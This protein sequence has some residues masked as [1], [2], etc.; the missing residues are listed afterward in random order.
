MQFITTQKRFSASLTAATLAA[1]TISTLSTLSTTLSAQVISS[2]S[3]SAAQLVQ[4]ESLST[5]A[6]SRAIFLEANPGAGL[7]ELE[8]QITRVYGAAFSHGTNA[9]D[10]AEKFLRAHSGMLSS[11]FAQLMAIGPNGDGTHVLPV[12]FNEQDGSH[13]F[14][15]VGYTQHVNGVPVF[16]ADVRCLVRN[17]PGYPLVLVSNSLRDVNEFAATD[18]SKIRAL[19]PSQINLSKVSRLPLN[20]FG[21]GATI[22]DQEQVIWAGYEETTAASPRVAI[23]FIVTGTGVFDRDSHQRMLYIVD[24]ATN[25][26]LFQEDQVLNA[27]VLVQVNGMGTIGTA[28]DACL[29]EGSE[30]LPYAKLTYGATTVY[31]N[32]AGAVTIPTTASISITSTVGGRWFSVNDSTNGT[33]GTLTT[34]SAGGALNFMHNAANTA[35]DQRAEVNAYIEAN[36]V[37]DYLLS[38]APAFP[39]IPSQTNWPINV[40]VAG[41]CNAFYDGASINFYPSGGG[42]NNTAFSVVVHHEYGHHIVNRAGSGQ[43]AYG[44]GF[45]DVMG[46][47]VTDESRLAVGFQTCSTGI[48]EANNACQYSSSGC[49]S[50]GSEIHACGQ[51][52]S[53]CVWDLRDNLLLSNPASYRSILSSLAVNS[54]LMHTGTGIAGDITVDF[55]TLDDNDGNINNGT[56]HYGDINNAFTVHGLPGPALQLIS[57]SFPSG[58]PAYSLPAG[59]TNLYFNAAAMS[60]TPAPNTGKLAYRVGTSGSFSVV[61]ATQIATNQYRVAIPAAPCGSTIQYYVAA[62]ATTGYVVTN[63]SDAPTTIFTTLS[64]SGLDT[65]FQDTVETNLGW[66]LTATGDTATTGQWVRNDPLGTLNGTTQVQ[67][68]TDVST[69]GVNCFFTGQGTAGGTLGEADVDGGYTSLTSPTM[70]ATGGEAYVSYSRWYSNNQGGSPNADTFRVMI[71]NNNGSTWTTLETVG[72]AGTEAGGG[73]VAKEIEIASVI[74]PTATMKLRFIAEDIGT[75]S[76]VEAAVDEVRIKVLACGNPLDLNSDGSVDAADLA[77]L[78]S[79]WGGQGSGDLNGDGAVDGGDLATLLGGW[80]S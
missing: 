42:C 36:L 30:A 1:A 16:R 6:A 10:S 49:S 28:A 74:A 14:S 12:M 68:E 20:Q 60:G 77:I 40:Q 75:G 64:A 66:V 24:A 41:T 31:A 13:K 2:A 3:A 26:I 9:V 47:L 52:I 18:G 32:A 38:Y 70:D 80:G 69:V 73:W 56:P 25:K 63:P 39:T 61:Y 48:R 46:V 58:Q 71:S 51:L 11:D 57:L 50:C 79:N 65:V 53:G 67:P 17:E 45:G 35:E 76:L 7:F 22:S 55:L 27:D 8:G 15:L 62:D 4:G 33:I 21:P 44:E 34:A 29:A 54:V 72:P 5:T 19:A 37:R 23:K 59:G 78:L 43:G